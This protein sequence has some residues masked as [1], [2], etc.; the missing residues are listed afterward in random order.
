MHLF[1]LHPFCN[2]LIV[3]S[4]IENNVVRSGTEAG[5]SLFEVQEDAVKLEGI[6]I[7]GGLY[8]EISLRFDA[9]IKLL[10]R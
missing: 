6:A 10:G 7:Y 5:C 1:Y 3:F 9:E 8:I 4:A 2:G